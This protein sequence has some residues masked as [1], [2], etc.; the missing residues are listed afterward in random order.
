MV[1]WYLLLDIDRVYLQVR[2]P[3]CLVQS[4]Y[5]PKVS[6]EVSV[7][8]PPCRLDNLVRL[9]HGGIGVKLLQSCLMGR[10]SLGILHGPQ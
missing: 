4:E 7:I 10:V 2:C 8:R 5:F 3:T 9:N 6:M 1:L